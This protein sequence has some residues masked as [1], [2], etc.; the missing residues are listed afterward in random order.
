MLRERIAELVSQAS[1]GELEAAEVLAADCPL[2]ALGVTSLVYIRLL[3]AIELEYGVDLDA[4]AG[5]LDT[6]DGLVASLEAAGR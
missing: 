4:E 6:L 5:W 1:G 2:P 3:D